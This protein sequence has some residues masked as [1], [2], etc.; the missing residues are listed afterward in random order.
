MRS[1]A[2]RWAAPITL[3]LLL[4]LLGYGLWWGWNQLTRPFANSNPCVT[5]SASVLI[6]TQVTVQVFNGGSQ[7]GLASQV[8][9]QL[10]YHGFK[11]K[12]PANTNE[13]VGATVI[14]GASAD[15]P[16]VQLVAGFFVDAQ[17]RGDERTD[18]TVDVLL[19]DSYAGFNDAAPT[20]IDVPGGVICVPEA[21]DQPATENA[22]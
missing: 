6:T 16:E 18:G 15:S 4:A 14:V 5:Q 7:A 21:T 1:S 19:G 2:R 22:G 12:S 10:A 11:T 8:S 17:T 9:E 13:Q 20:S 3:L